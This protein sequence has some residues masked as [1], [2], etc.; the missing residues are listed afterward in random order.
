MGPY[1]QHLGQNLVA[2]ERSYR[3]MLMLADKLDGLLLRINNLEEA[4]TRTCSEMQGMAA[5]LS[6]EA[7]SPGMDQLKQEEEV[8]D[9]RHKRKKLVHISEEEPVQAIL[10]QVQGHLTTRMQEI[11]QK[12]RTEI[13]DGMEPSASIVQRKRKKNECDAFLQFLNLFDDL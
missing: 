10:R 6:A 13:H 5:E 1:T 8:S 4:V 12:M 2:Y 11:E 7:E 3:A 9:E